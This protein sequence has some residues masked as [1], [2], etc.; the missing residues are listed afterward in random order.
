MNEWD[1]IQ[2]R[3]LFNLRKNSSQDAANYLEALANKI[4]P[5]IPYGIRDEVLKP[6]YQY[7]EQLK[8]PVNSEEDPKKASTEAKTN[9]LKELGILRP[10]KPRKYIAEDIYDLYLTY[11]HDGCLDENK[12]RIQTA[13]DLGIDRRRV[14][15]VIEDK[16]SNNLKT[17]MKYAPE[18]LNNKD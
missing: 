1:D 6:F 2:L 9:F 7:G 15:E 8:T 10:G 17:F 13:K 14:D 16:R 3:K 5:V 18:T 4:A 12:A 11:R